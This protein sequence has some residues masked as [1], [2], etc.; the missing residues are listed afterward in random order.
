MHL[1]T[2]TRHIYSYPE[3]SIASNPFSRSS[4]HTL[5]HPSI[6]KHDEKLNIRTHS[7]PQQEP[8]EW[9]IIKAEKVTFCWSEN[10][11]CSNLEGEIVASEF[12]H[13]SSEYEFEFEWNT[14]HTHTY[15]HT[16]L[17]N[18]EKWKYYAFYVVP[19]G[20]AFIPPLY[21][22]LLLLLLPPGLS[23]LNG[24]DV[25]GDTTREQ[26]HTQDASPLRTH[27]HNHT[28]TEMWTETI[29]CWPEWKWN[30]L[31]TEKF[32][33]QT[34]CSLNP[35]AYMYLSI[36]QACAIAAGGNLQTTVR[37]FFFCFDF[38][39]IC[40]PTGSHSSKWI[41]WCAFCAKVF[42]APFVWCEL[43]AMDNL[44]PSFVSFWSRY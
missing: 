25:D 29:L 18:D 20:L 6:E 23:N 30:K 39:L 32:V 14:V 26:K 7:F 1:H 10:F 2:L 41:N 22:L 33:Q 12:Y 19:N 5:L 16:K 21:T 17:C 9:K 35:F 43:W 44:Y 40:R 37:C 38:L 36:T 11:Q 31:K 13:S 15:S 27:I 28:I 4:W 8:N 24:N 34:F 3:K 42:V